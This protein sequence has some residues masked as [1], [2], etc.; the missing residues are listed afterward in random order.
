MYLKNK[1]E[2]KKKNSF[3]SYDIYIEGGPAPPAESS[4][5][6]CAEALYPKRSLRR[7][8]KYGKE[9]TLGGPFDGNTTEFKDFEEKVLKTDSNA[10][11]EWMCSDTLKKYVQSEGGLLE[12]IDDKRDSFGLYRATIPATVS[13]KD[14]CGQVLA[15]ILYRDTTVG[16]TR[17]V[18]VDLICRGDRVE[19]ERTKH[20]FVP[21]KVLHQYMEDAVVDSTPSNI[22]RVQFSLDSVPGAIETYEKWGYSTIVYKNQPVNNEVLNARPMVKVFERSQNVSNGSGIFVPFDGKTHAFKLN[23]L[24]EDVNFEDSDYGKVVVVAETAETTNRRTRN[25]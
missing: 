16:D 23:R 15:F 7:S 1:F 21:G 20:A 6:L 19:D 25:A 3:M 9:V 18:H 24:K 22:A 4:V 10:S 13:G 17:F 8:P 11:L 14:A 5:G 2:T 12:K